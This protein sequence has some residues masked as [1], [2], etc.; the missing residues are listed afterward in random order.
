M[1]CGLPE[2]MMMPFGTA[3]GAETDLALMLETK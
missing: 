1:S 2:I 3:Q